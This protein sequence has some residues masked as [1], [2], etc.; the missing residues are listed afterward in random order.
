MQILGLPPAKQSWSRCPKDVSVGVDGFLPL[1]R[2]GIFVPT[3]CKESGSAFFE[4]QVVTRNFFVLNAV[5][6]QDFLFYQGKD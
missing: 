5:C 3:E 2:S 6:V 4:Y 1:Q